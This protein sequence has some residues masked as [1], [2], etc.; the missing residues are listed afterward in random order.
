MS[1]VGNI[2]MTLIEQ[3]EEP[4]TGY[5]LTK[6][7]GP[8]TKH[9]HQQIYREL[10]K[11]QRKGWIACRIVPQ[12]GKPDRK[13]FVTTPYAEYE[14]IVV[15]ATPFYRTQAS[16]SLFA[17]DVAD[18]TEYFADYVYYM[19]L[20]ER[21]ILQRIAKEKGIEFEEFCNYPSVERIDMYPVIEEEEEAIE[22]ETEQEEVAEAE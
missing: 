17:Q 13:E 12:E 10:A 14:D 3:N 9:A 8:T 18:E 15:T 5:S 20:A 16:Y 1:T 11:L 19:Q 7:L 6:K 4:I 22:E 21:R 2:L